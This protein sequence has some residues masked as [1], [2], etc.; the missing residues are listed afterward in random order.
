MSEAIRPKYDVAISFLSSDE[1]IAAGFYEALS[2][3]LEVFFYPRKQE[4]LAGT[5]G[6]VS[7][8]A[9]FVEKARIVVV[10]YREPWGKTP[11]TRVEE[12]AIQDGCL[13][14]GWERLFFVMLDNG[15]PPPWV[16]S[17][18]VRFN[19]SDFGL[20][21]AIGAI[22]ARVQEAGG[23]I[24]PLTALKRAELSKQETQFLEEKDQLRSASGRE[25]VQRETS[26]LFAAIER[27]C[28]QVNAGGNASIDIT[29]ESHQCHLRG[30]RV[31][32]V[33]NLR[34]SHSGCELTVREFDGRLP[35]PGE[36]LYYPDGEPKVLC[37]IRFLP[38]L[39]RAREYGWADQ[40]QPLV[41]LPSEMLADK[42]V[43]RFIDLAT[44]SERGELIRARRHTR[45]ISRYRSLDT[46]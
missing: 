16:P 6:L 26:K 5:N 20:E 8:S 39:N 38:E 7:M 22:K 28:S 4:E 12:A 24:A 10:L 46:M 9:P 33:V 43:V 30:R 11:W 37:E 31:S 17:A 40:A 23:T 29:S 25:V 42:I 32:L 14:R 3:G 27:V 41:F 18:H 36:R 19:Y 45:R 13:K 44:R 15:S 1:S 35:M 34:L 2:N 21:Q